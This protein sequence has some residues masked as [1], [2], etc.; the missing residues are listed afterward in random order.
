MTCEPLRGRHLV[1]FAFASLSQAAW[2]IFDTYLVAGWLGGL[3]NE[4]MYE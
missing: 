4:W 2:Q 1:L 3:M